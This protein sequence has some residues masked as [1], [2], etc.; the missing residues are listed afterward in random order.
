MIF[1]NTLRSIDASVDMSASLGGTLIASAICSK[2][3][4]LFLQTYSNAVTHRIST[5]V[6]FERCNVHIIA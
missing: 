3:I 5:L 1:D 4:G 6:S 2:L